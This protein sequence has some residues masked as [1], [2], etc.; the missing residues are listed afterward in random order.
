MT[1]DLPP[2]RLAGRLVLKALLGG[3]LILCLTSAA[4]ASAV[5]LQVDNLKGHL[6]PTPPAPFKPGV[7]SKAKAGEPQ[8]LL[9]VG[10]D[11]R[12]GDAKGDARSDT[13]MLVRLDPKQQATAVLNVP[14]DLVVDIPG[15]GRAKINEAYALGGLNLVVETVKATLGLAKV[16]HAMAVDFKGFRKVVNALNCVYVDVDRHYFN[17]NSGPGPGYATIDVREGYQKLCGQAALDYV[18]YRHGDSDF[19]RAAR[20]Q[21]F[22]RDAKDQVSTSSLIGKRN[23]LLDIFGRSAQ[24]DPG[25]HHAKQLVRL[26]EQAAL[27][28]GKPVRQLKFPAQDELDDSEGG[29]GSYLAAS[30]EALT[31]IRLKFLS[32]TRPKD[33]LVRPRVVRDGAKRAA[34]GRRTTLADFGLVDDKKEGERIVAPLEARDAVHFPV[35]FPQG[36]TKR[37]HWTGTPPRPRVYEI[38]DRAGK[39]QEAYRMVFT[40]DPVN[41]DYYGVQGTTWRTPPILARGGERLRMRGREYRLF[42]DGQKL[43]V[44]AWRTRSATYWVSNTLGL[45]LTN[46]EML[47]IARSLT[48]LGA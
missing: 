15:H 20:Q 19:V 28:A 2:P 21:D 48:R 12:Y 46:T 30:P 36:L 35:Y 7:I 22:L 42:Y 3:L 16:H 37:A 29:F 8:T 26:A 31:A 5:F 24:T 44:V 10:T 45:A 14:R 25:L 1:P 47:G 43:R 40:Q 17:D 13:M 23:E 6:A 11:H 33:R 32:A 9:I 41:G 4:V 34:R 39:P 27:S 18:R 38:T